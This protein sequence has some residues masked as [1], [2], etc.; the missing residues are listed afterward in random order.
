MNRIG[1][2]A[3][4]LLGGLLL[5]P[6]IGAAEPDGLPLS[7]LA[8]ETRAEILKQLPKKSM[9][10]VIGDGP[11]RSP[12][13][14]AGRTYADLL[15]GVGESGPDTIRVALFRI[16]WE[17]DSAGDLTTADNG[18]F[19]VEPDPDWPNIVDAPPHDSVYFHTHMEVLR[20]FIREQS[21]GKLHVE[22]DIYPKSLSGA[23]RLHDTSDYLP[24]GDPSGW[25]LI[26][27]SDLLVKFSTDAIVL[28]DT[29]DPSVRFSDY[30]GYLLFHAGPD[31]QTD[32]NRDSPGD[33]P[34]FFLTLGD[35]DFV[36][37]DID[38]SAGTAD[39]VWNMTVVPEY[40]SQDGF[41]FGVNGVLAHEFGHQ[42]GLPDLY[43][44]NTFWPAVG[45]WD[46]MDSGGL[47]SID[48]GGVFL[49]GIIPGS[50]SAWSKVYLG[51]VTPRI[52]NS[53]GSFSLA[54]A[55]HPSPPEDSDRYALIP[56]N[57]QEYYLLENRMGLAPVD[58]FAARQDTVNGVI[59]GPVDFD[60]SDTFTF[61][62]DF[63]LPG[64]GTLIW[65]I[66]ERHFDPF[67]LAANIVNVNF[68]DRA[69]ELE[70]A[71]G[72]KDLGNPFSAFWDGSSQDP[73]FEGNATRFGPDTRPN[74]DLTDGARSM[75]EVNVFGEADSL[76]TIQVDLRPNIPGFPLPLTADS[77]IVEPAG[78]LQP[79]VDQLLAF[80]ISIDSL[81]ELIGGVTSAQVKGDE[82][83]VRRAL[84]PELPVTFAVAGEL[85]VEGKSIP[86]P[87]NEAVTI[88][89]GRLYEIDPAEDDLIRDVGPIR[90]GNVQA[91]PLL[92]D[93]DGDGFD[94]VIIAVGDSIA[95]YRLVA[96]SL[97]II[98][99]AALAGTLA[100]NLSAYR[101]ESTIDIRYVTTAGGFYRLD[102]TTDG[103]DYPATV[104]VADLGR[105]VY[106]SLVNGDLAREGNRDWIVAL[107]EGSVH[108]WNSRG[109]IRD[110]WPVELVRPLTGDLFF[111]DEDGDGFPEVAV[112]SD[113]SLLLLERN[114][115]PSTDTPLRIPTILDLGFPLVANGLSGPVSHDGRS[116]P[117][118]GDAGGRI[119]SWVSGEKVLDGWPVSTGTWST[120]LNAGPLLRNHEEWSLYA[121]SRDGFVYAFPLGIDRDEPFLWTG[122]GGGAAGRN[123]LV[124]DLLDPAENPAGGPARILEAYCYPNPVRRG[125]PLLRYELSADA[126]VK[127][128]LVD[129]AGQQL[130]AFRAAG[131]FGSN[132]LVLET[133]HLASGVYYLRVEAEGDVEFVKM[134][135]I[136]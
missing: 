131:R 96:D 72:I 34:S 112:P 100:S 6:G 50:F 124:T 30:D 46:L 12:L 24:E 120:I 49:T 8:P 114:G 135:I 37:V 59:L 35:S 58:R 45:Q 115:V 95:A 28:V 128:D 60:D 102:F 86:V 90:P 22:W 5:L 54:A 26:Q 87:F 27:R 13:R 52:M 21:Y 77:T 70:E 17:E 68:F 79:A 93:T 98:W 129:L 40:D 71:D 18:R 117:I 97:E 41:I 57:D 44:T 123:G 33:I 7:R 89:G 56:L 136:R 15:K 122:P 32:I 66:N 99:E 2:P 16:E 101:N 82:L 127:V 121:E 119:W 107:A 91:D 23:Y 48:G 111:S 11:L 63:S 85:R 103:P 61:D 116:L 64:W 3:S 92:L 80:W 19:L 78:L 134:A 43:N 125:R 25:D 104:S 108:A 36:L 130:S 74:S 105:T 31:V 42:L 94:E 39:T 4:L 75:V 10:C 20:T 113:Q 106:A 67:S 9:G 51:W 110:G 126:D 81:D 88:A 55:T 109:E 133:D 29:V 62:Y 47:V 14:G 69:L 84:F 83:I 118:M 132:E 1:I 53:P 65:H 76:M 73:W 38:A